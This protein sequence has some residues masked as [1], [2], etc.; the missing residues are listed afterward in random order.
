MLISGEGQFVLQRPVCPIGVMWGG[1]FQVGVLAQK[2]SEFVG[3]Y[4][5]LKNRAV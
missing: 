4:I 5:I 3:C 1:G 2:T